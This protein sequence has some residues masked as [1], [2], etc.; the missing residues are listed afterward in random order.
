MLISRSFWRN[1]V[2]TIGAAV[3]LVFVYETTIPDSWYVTRQGTSSS[4]S[5]TPK[6]GARL[7]FMAT[8]YCKGDTTASGVGVR[9]GIAAADPSL[10]PVGTVVRVDA[11]D[12]KLDGIWT[13]MDTGPSV[14]GRIIDL[15]MWSCHEALR[16]G[17]RPVQLEVLRLGWN[18][19]NSQP[20]RVQS[21]FYQREKSRPITA[22]VPKAEPAAAPAPVD[23]APAVAPPPSS[24]L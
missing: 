11:S 3:G 8:A 22:P 9:T 4:A 18:P 7:R 13:V 21:L 6:A 12:A 20:G 15:Y 2:A 14:Q 23:D 16:V 24:Q 5:A 1:V 17:R 10:L 19:Q